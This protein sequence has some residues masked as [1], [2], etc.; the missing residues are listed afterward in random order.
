MLM[1][2]ILADHYNDADEALYHRVLLRVRRYI[3][4]RRAFKP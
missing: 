2:A 1:H 3:D 4:Q